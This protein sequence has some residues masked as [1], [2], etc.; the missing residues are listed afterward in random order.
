MASNNPPNKETVDYPHPAV[1]VDKMLTERSSS[2]VGTFAPIE[3]GQ[4]YVNLNHSV[5]QAADYAGLISL[6]QKAGQDREFQERFWASDPKTQDIWNYEVSYGSKNN[7]FPIF[8]RKYLEK[9]DD[10]T[11]RTDL[12][13]LTSLYAVHI[14]APGSGYDPANPPLVTCNNG[15]TAIALVDPTNGAIA[16]ITLKIEGLNCNTTVTIAAPPAGGVQATAV[17]VLQPANCL[18]IDESAAPAQDP[19]GSLYL[20]VDRTYET[21]P[22]DIEFDIVPDAELGIPVMTT[23]QR[24]PSTAYWPCGKFAPVSFN[25]SGATIATQTVVTTSAPHDFYVDEFVVVTGTANTT[26][27]LD[28]TWRVV[29]VPSPT[30]VVLDKTITGV[31]GAVGGTIRRYS[32]VYVERRKTDNTNVVLKVTTRAAVSDITAYNY[33][34]IT[35]RKYSFPDALTGAVGAA[36]NSNS[37]TT[38]PTEWAIAYSYSGTVALEIQNGYRG[39]VWSKRIRVFSMGPFQAVPTDPDTG[40]PYQFTVIMPATGM[41]TIKGGS[42]SER[43]T[44]T[45]MTTSTSSSAKAQTIPPVLTGAFGGITGGG[46]RVAYGGF[47]PAS[48]PP[49]FTVGD[50]ILEHDDVVQ[51]RATEVYMWTISKILVPY[52]TGQNPPG[53]LPVPPWP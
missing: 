17:G 4:P 31:S 36:D 46:G 28:G 2:F 53:T 33:E 48:V 50:T 3:P 44:A 12:T 11:P 13:P 45:G 30:T 51:L 23:E 37:T 19:W 40:Q 47:L 8:K 35:P 24:W 42:F 41:V 6:S 15:A 9:R 26:P 7:L 32:W 1:V 43:L 5:A 16:K 22:G 29:S 21:L 49:L 20:V 38:E 52:T 39:N 10:Y 34:T 25:I 14:T 18:L 27:S